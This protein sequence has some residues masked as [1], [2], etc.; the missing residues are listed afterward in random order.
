MP[1]QV[2]D[3]TVH[4]IA[5]YQLRA[6][7]ETDHGL[8]GDQDLARSVAETRVWL[9]SYSD[10]PDAS[11]VPMR[12]DDE[13]HARRTELDVIFDSA[14]ADH[15]P[16]IARLRDGGQLSF[17][18]TTELLADALRAQDARTRW[19]LA[20]WPHVVEYAEIGRALEAGVGADPVEATM[21]DVA[22]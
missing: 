9:A 19:I 4:E 16:L 7:L 12:T 10:A 18:E 8:G 21:L 5:A 3:D 6:H 17:D 1:A 13:M 20:H 14:P 22:T 2:W 11:V 15:R